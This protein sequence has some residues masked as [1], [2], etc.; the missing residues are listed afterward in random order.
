MRH[1]G[2][3]QGH[4]G[5]DHREV[6]RQ[7]PVDGHRHAPATE[8]AAAVV[9]HVQALAT[10]TTWP[11]FHDG[12]PILAAPI[13]VAI[14]P[15]AGHVSHVGIGFEAVCGQD[16]HGPVPPFGGGSTVVPSMFILISRTYS[17]RVICSTD[18]S[19]VSTAISS[20]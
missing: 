17:T 3:V 2:D 16:R 14:A 7:R 15:A 13:R 11:H 19:V 9:P 1:V 10:E 5:E 12:R 20:A 8:A 4:A 18:V 6:A